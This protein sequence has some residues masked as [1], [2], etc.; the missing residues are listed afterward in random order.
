MRFISLASLVHYGEMSLSIT[1]RGKICREITKKMSIKSRDF[2]IQM[3]HQQ[4][5]DNKLAEVET[6]AQ[7]SELVIYG[8]Y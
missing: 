2:S 8:V 7:F 3:E 6:V 4:I 1:E 5:S